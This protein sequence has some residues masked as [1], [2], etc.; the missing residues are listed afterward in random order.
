M[1]DAEQVDYLVKGEAELRR[2]VSA[3]AEALAIAGNGLT[4]E[5]RVPIQFNSAYNSNH[6]SD[7]TALKKLA[8]TFMAEGRLAEL[9]NCPGYA[10]KSYLDTME[11]GIK[12]AHGGVLID[13]L[14]GTPLKQ[15]E[16][17]RLKRSL[18]ISMRKPAGKSPPPWKR[19]KR[20]GRRGRKP[21]SRKRRGR[22]GLFP[23]C[24][25][26]FKR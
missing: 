18:A 15:T 14:V 11:L 20:K 22:A 7:L 26:G 8:F 1:L 12:S 21:C 10:V 19:S 25:T 17:S 16:G 24:T 9:E 5:C 4:N 6:L 2:Q 23:D 3:N 13:Q